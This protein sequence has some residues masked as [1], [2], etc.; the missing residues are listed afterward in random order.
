MRPIRAA[1]A[2][3]VLLA[4]PGSAIAA[5]VDIAPTTSL[6]S[7]QARVA[8]TGGSSFVRWS[9]PERVAVVARGSEPLLGRLVRN[10]G[11]ETAA[12]SGGGSVVRRSFAASPDG[13]AALDQI[14]PSVRTLLARARAGTT[15]LRTFRVGARRTL[16]GTVRVAAN[17]CAGLRGGVKMIDLDARTLLPVRI[18]TRR[19]GARTQTTRLAGLRIN[20]RLRANAFRPLRPRGSVFRTDQGFRRTS[21]VVAA[22]HL[23]YSPKLPGAVPA[24]FTL[25]VSGWAPRS[26]ITGPEGSIPARPALFAAVYARGGEQIEVTQRRAIGGDWPGDPF[27]GECQPLSARSVTVGGIAATYALGAETG[28]HL[29]WREGAVLH[30]VSGPFPADD[31]VAVAESLTPVVRP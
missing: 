16:R 3:S 24:G 14:D 11:L 21:A 25:A 19:A 26:A 5:A 12:Y 10:R 8:A 28:P 6:K 23:P 20:P 15:A 13:V 27:G 1:A 18:V 4:V 7:F 31:L 2:L 9:G 22:G 17:D 29:Y 30:T